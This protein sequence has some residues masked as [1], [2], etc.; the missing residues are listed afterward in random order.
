MFTSHTS[1]VIEKTAMAIMK[2]LDDRETE[3]TKEQQKIKRE[4]LKENIKK[5]K[6]SNDF[7]D[8][9]LKKCKEHGMVVQ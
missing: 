9:L 5:K 1:E 6:R 7:V 4:K 8:I 3:W 2:A